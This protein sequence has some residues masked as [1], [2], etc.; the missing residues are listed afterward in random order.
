MGTVWRQSRAIRDDE[1]LVTYVARLV[2]SKDPLQFVGVAADVT[3]QHSRARFVLVGDGP[4]RAAILAAAA[5][6]G[7]GD[8]L[9]IVGQEADL[10]GV[11]AASDVFL[12]TSTYEGFGIAMLEA[13]ASAT[14]VVA[15]SVGGV[16]ELVISGT[17]GLLVAPGDKDGLVSAVLKLLRDEDA[18]L[19]MGSAARARA[20]ELFDA[21]RMTASYEHLYESIVRSPAPRKPARSLTAQSTAN[22]PR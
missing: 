17:T 22:Q 14:P 2:P 10:A 8:R 13:M 19:R 11:L 5:E 4:E 12:S 21:S 16:P 7:L 3:D 20:A 6:R 9:L 15:T 1:L 18:R